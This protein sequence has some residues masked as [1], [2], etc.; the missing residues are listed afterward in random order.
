V[1]TYEGERGHPVLIARSHFD[2]AM[3]LTGD[4]GA[5]SLLVA[6]DVV[7]VPCDGTGDARD[8]DTPADL[9]ALEGGS[10]A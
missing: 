2:E 8:V 6:H 10:P 1:A 7:E 9:A 5:R 4:E 3:H